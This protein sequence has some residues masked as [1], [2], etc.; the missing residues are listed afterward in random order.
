M[1]NLR[2]VL[3]GPWRA[4]LR[5]PHDGACAAG[6]VHQLWTVSVIVAVA[7]PPTVAANE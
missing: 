1:A 5:S 7:T 2:S 6:K 3:A 4:Q